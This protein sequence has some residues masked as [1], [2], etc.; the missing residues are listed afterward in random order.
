MVLATQNPIE[1]EGTYPLPEA[2]RDRFMARHLDGLPGRGRRA[3]HARPTTPA[4]T[5]W[6]RCSRCPTRH[7]GAPA[8]R[9]G[10]HASTS[11]TRSGST[12]WSWSTPPARAP[13]LR[14]G[15]S[16][17]AALHLLRAAQ[18]ARPRWTAATT[19]CPTTCSGWPC[20]CWRTGCCSP[21]R[22]RSARRTAEQV[23]ADVLR[24]VPV[25]APG[26]RAAGRPEGL[27]RVR[28][29]LSGLTTRGRCLLAAGLAAALCALAA[30]R[31]RPAAGRR[32]AGRAAAGRRARGGAHPVPAVLHARRWH[33]ARVPAGQPAERAAAAGER[34][35]LP[36]GL[37]LLEDQVPYTLG[38]RPRFVRRPGRAAASGREVRYRVRSDA[39]GALP[40]R[41]AAAAAGRPVRAGAS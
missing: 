6:T 1:M 26:G 14:L 32:P 31:A 20:R 39:R 5:R 22:P 23:V 7:R 19:C 25:P 3:G 40:D 33:P 11:P 38:G 36:T 8:D 10:P 29:A 21:R 4:A 24:S 30:R 9:R 35:A 41:P 27:S 15:A 37:L 17:R 18:G 2:Q 28:A 34:L 13:D 16:P 12:W